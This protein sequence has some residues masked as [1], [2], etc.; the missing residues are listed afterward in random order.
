[1]WGGYTYVQNFVHLSLLLARDDDEA[2]TSLFLPDAIN[3]LRPRGKGAISVTTPILFVNQ[4]DQPQAFFRVDSGEYRMSFRDQCPALARATTFLTEHAAPF[5][6]GSHFV[7]L[8]EKGQGCIV[9]NWA[10]IH[11][12][13]PFIDDMSA[14]RRRVLARK[15]FMA[16]ESQAKYKHVPGMHIKRLYAD[17]FPSKFG[18]D[19]LEGDWN[20]RPELSDN[21]KNS[22]VPAGVEQELTV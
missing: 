5:A 8:M 1:M 15:W 13:T 6:P 20:W 9:R 3:A 4:W 16:E 11:G 19:R 12:R 22:H 14:G 18:E 7:G 17:I 10:C 2:F 21:V